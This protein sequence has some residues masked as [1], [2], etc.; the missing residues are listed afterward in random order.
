MCT[1]STSCSCVAGPGKQH[2]IKII[3]SGCLPP[4]PFGLMP[5]CRPQLPLKRSLNEIQHFPLIFFH[6]DAVSGAQ[7]THSN[8]QRR[9]RPSTSLVALTVARDGSLGY[10]EVFIKPCFAILQCSMVELYLAE[11]E[12]DTDEVGRTRRA[13]LWAGG[14]SGAGFSFHFNILPRVFR[15]S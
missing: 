15:A 6:S 3:H 13:C 2:V 10:F 9:R 8:S 14:G 12:R 7:R 11:K 4:T 1:A 5:L